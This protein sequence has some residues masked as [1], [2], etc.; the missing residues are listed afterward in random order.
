MVIT[1]SNMVLHCKNCKY[2]NLLD[3]RAIVDALTAVPTHLETY[4]HEKGKHLVS[5]T[6]PLRKNTK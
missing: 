2:Q 5:I 6:I 4:R 1:K 3:P